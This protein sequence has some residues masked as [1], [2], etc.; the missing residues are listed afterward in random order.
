RLIHAVPK[1]HIVGHIQECQIRFPCDYKEGFGRVYGEGV[2]AIWAEDNQQSS[3]LREMN[4]G[5]RQDV[6]EDNHLFWNTRKTQEI[7][8]FVWFAL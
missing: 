8:M 7:G 1:K 6:T 5:M 3:S 4:P 2:E